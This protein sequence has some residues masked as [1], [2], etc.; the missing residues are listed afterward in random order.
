MS[1]HLREE[2]Y[3][4]YLDG[5]LEAPER[6][7][8]DEHLAACDACRARLDEMRSVMGVLDEWK[9]VEASPAFDAALRA[10]LE[11][12]KTQPVGWLVFR[13]AYAVALAAAVLLALAL[14]FW[15]SATPGPAPDMVQTPPQATEEVAQVTPPVQ[16]T[17]TD[18]AEETEDLAA[19]EVMENY[20]LL[21]QF[22]ILFDPLNGEEKL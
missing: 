15:P 18:A 9:A 11:Q 16:T 17:G 14:T 3:I 6:S 4:P 22:D 5:G 20:E 8:V 13:P 19:L 7:R 10:R 12:E 1:T 2:D 21:D